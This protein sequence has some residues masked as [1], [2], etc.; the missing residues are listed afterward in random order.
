ML[1]LRGLAYYVNPLRGSNR[2][3]RATAIDDDEPRIGDGSA[4]ATKAA[5]TLER[6]DA[7][8]IVVED[9]NASGQRCLWSAAFKGG[10]LCNCDFIVSEGRQGLSVAFQSAIKIRRRVWVSDEFAT[11]QP[12]ATKI[13]K[14]VCQIV[15]D[16][17]A[18]FA[19]YALKKTDAN[20]LSELVPLV[21][22]RE[23]SHGIG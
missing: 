2:F 14:S 19:V 23:K 22:K 11:M 3:L 9:V 17:L 15:M 18:A 6:A 4:L 12:S 21:S 13:L 16:D 20:K 8:T 10:L 7:Y 1:P 5:L